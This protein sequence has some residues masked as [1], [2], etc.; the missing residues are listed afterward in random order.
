MAFKQLSPESV[1]YLVVHCSASKP[2]LKTDVKTID[3]WHRQ[4]GFAKVGYHFVI[5]TDGTV[6][7]GRQ[8]TE[9]GA[10]AQGYN[11]QSIGICMVGGIDPNG[12]PSDNFTVEQKESLRGLL[13]KLSHVYK[14][15]SI[16]GHRDLPGVKKDCPCFDVRAW[17]NDA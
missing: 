15:A 8:L 9:I 4:R 10:H 17:L 2:D 5:K 13:M 16:V 7:V 12:K 6:Q 11:A 1:K 14:M 3:R